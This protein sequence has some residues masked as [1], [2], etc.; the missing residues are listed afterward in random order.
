MPKTKKRPY[1]TSK[2]K[3]GAA[4][5]REDARVLSPETIA[6]LDRIAAESK[7]G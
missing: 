7:K 2:K 1:R 5:G 6:R 3:K 4:G